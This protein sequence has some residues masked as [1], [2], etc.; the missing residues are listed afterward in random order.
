MLTVIATFIALFR[1]EPIVW[2]SYVPLA[3]LF[4]LMLTGMYLFVQPYLNRG[5]RRIAAS[6]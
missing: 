2:V 6:E 1:K 5:A 3:P 4:L